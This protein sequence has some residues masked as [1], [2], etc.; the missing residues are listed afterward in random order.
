LAPAKAGASGEDNMGEKHSP[1]IRK[2]FSD[3]WD[4]VYLDD[5][6]IA[7]GHDIY[8]MD[9]LDE[10]SKRGLL[11]AEVE[12][13]SREVDPDWMEEVAGGNLP[14]SYKEVVFH[15]NEQ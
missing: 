9:L 2:V 3:D 7:E 10:L 4:G 12:W 5:E 11:G 13:P 8:L 1:R 14:T 6:L 15:D